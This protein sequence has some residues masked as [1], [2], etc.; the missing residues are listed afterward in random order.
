MKLRQAFDDFEKLEMKEQLEKVALQMHRN[1]MRYPEA[2]REFQKVFITTVLR[3]QK[4]NQV[5]AAEKL[6]MHRNTLRRTIRELEIDIRSFRVTR[7]RPPMSEG[8]AVVQAKKQE[9]PG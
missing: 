6:Q 7:R 9:R 3:E 8:R 1:G 4:A 5:R 2:V